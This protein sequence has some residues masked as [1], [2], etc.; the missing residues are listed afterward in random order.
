[1]G[2]SDRLETKAHLAL[3]LLIA[4]MLC[5]CVFGT[6]GSLMSGVG[7]L[8]RSRSGAGV[9]SPRDASWM[10]LNPASIVELD[11][12]FDI[13][14]S[15][16]LSD[17]T[18]EGGGL[19]GNHFAGKMTYSQSFLIPSG[20]LILP[21]SGDGTFG[22][23]VYVP[24]G[25][26]VNYP[27]SRDILSRLLYH[28]TDRRLQLQHI[29]AVCAYGRRFGQGWALGI[30]LKGSWT[31]FRT[32]SLTLNF[33]NTEAENDWDDAFG[34]GF[35]LGVYRKWE[36]L[37]FGASYS[38]P[39]WSQKHHDYDDLIRYSI[40]M[41][42]ILQ[43]GIAYDLTPEVE[44]V[45]DYKYIDWQGLHLPGDEAFA[46]GLG[47]ESQHIVKIGVEWRVNEKW[48]LRGGLSHGNR[49]INEEHV[50]LNGLT[51]AGIIK[52][53]ISCGLSYY[54]NDRSEFHL[55]YTHAVKT[56]ITDSGRGD[57]L[58]FLGRGTTL[59]LSHDDITIAYSYK[60]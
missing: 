30:A 39:Q 33:T 4:M 36:K 24:S 34:L 31:R 7:P 51:A 19:L 54:I 38:S 25:L 60:F 40:D 42:Q 53:H 58:S 57:I 59:G 17:C 50:F 21:G 23:G 20:G 22:V 52:D 29:Q 14:L 49:T 9:A 2:R 43:I 10:T 5:A 15:V 37:A 32:D 41:P 35:A 45:A 56:D 1:M 16:F 26:C 47:W 55:S 6:E 27:V 48:A 44:L 13:D 18:S 28:N 3:I 46:G 12:R 11:R 8:Q